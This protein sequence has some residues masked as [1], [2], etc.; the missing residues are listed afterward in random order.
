MAFSNEIYKLHPDDHK[1][2]RI[3]L[4]SN[5]KFYKKLSEKR[6]SKKWHYLKKEN[7]TSPKEIVDKLATTLANSSG[8]ANMQK[9]LEKFTHQL[10][11]CR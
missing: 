1:A 3:E 7:G 10:H 2:K 11:H 9:Q 4:T 8:K 6:S 5:N